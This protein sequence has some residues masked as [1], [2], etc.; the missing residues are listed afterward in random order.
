MFE[1]DLLPAAVAANNKV[2]AWRVLNNVPGT[3]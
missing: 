3:A 1:F 2:P